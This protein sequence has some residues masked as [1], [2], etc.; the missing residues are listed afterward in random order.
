MDINYA[1]MIILF[2]MIYIGKVVLV[3]ILFNM[4]NDST[5]TLWVYKKLVYICVSKRKFVLCL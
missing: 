3:F 4:N 5:D 1:I 2:V